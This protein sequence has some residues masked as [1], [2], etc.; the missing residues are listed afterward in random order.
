MEAMLEKLRLRLQE[1][2]GRNAA[3]A[4]LFSGGLDSS[5]LAFLSS[6]GIHAL[7][8][9]LEEYGEDFKYARMLSQELGFRLHLRKVN[10]EEALEAIPEVIKIRRSFDPALPNDLALYFALRLAKGEGFES[11]MIGDGSDELFAGYSYM[12]DLNL[13][14]Y[15]PK[16]ADRMNFSAGELGLHLGIQVKQPFLDVEFVSL[17]LSIK[18][19]LKVRE[20]DG[21]R[22]GKWIL[23]KAFETFLPQEVVWQDKRPIETGSGF[24]ELRGIIAS[25]ISEE[26]FAEAKSSYPIKFLCK[27]HPFYYRIYREVVGEIPPPKPGEE[28]CPGCGAGIKASSFHCRICG[29]CQGVE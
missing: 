22:H 12:F 13:E 7:S 6:P 29:W 17:A 26:E 21:K 9:R 4:L 18:P 25:N 23:R 15:L 5:I 10:V 2:V 20:E 27:D 19:D 3:K 8:V 24:S 16:L 11:V 14:R 28:K 1:A